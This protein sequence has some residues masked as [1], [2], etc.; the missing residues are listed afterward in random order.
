MQELDRVGVE[1]KKKKKD[2]KNPTITKDSH[3]EYL[4]KALNGGQCMAVELQLLP[5]D[6]QGRALPAGY[7][8]SMLT[9]SP[10]CAWGH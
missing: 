4:G 10:L 8:R 9:G 3:T 2:E 7:A 6:R 5:E 1:L